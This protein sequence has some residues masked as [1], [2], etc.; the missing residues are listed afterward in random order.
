MY[1]VKPANKQNAEISSV[2]VDGRKR[3]TINH[4]TGICSKGVFFFFF[5]GGGGVV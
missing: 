2:K 4:K 1:R 5:G 3:R